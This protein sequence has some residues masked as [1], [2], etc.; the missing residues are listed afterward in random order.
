MSAVYYQV[1]AM[2]KKKPLTR[3]DKA[4]IAAGFQ[5]AACDVLV[6]KSFRACRQYPVKTLVVGGGVSANNRL[7]DK[8]MQSSQKN[9]LEIIFPEQSLCVDNA[10]MVAALGQAMFAARSKTAGSRT[11][12]KRSLGFKAYSDF[13]VHSPL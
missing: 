8:F 2:K 10:V 1:S 3:K 5:E 9:G 6:K 13:L 12:R 4:E 11:Q 7:R